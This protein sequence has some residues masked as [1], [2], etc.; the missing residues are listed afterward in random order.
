MIVVFSDETV[1]RNIKDIRKKYHISQIGLAKLTGI[2]VQKLR[3]IENGILREMDASFLLRIGEI[4][5]IDVEK[6]QKN[7]I[8]SD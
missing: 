4:F 7:Q 8:I 2:S 1:G 5:A 6:L 3:L